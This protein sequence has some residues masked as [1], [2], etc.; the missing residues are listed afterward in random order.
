MKIGVIADTHDNLRFLNKVLDYLNKQEIS[1]L[2]HCGDWGQPF[3]MRMLT[4]LK[5]PIK[6]VLGNADPDIQKFLY[7]LQNL[8]ILKD[9]DL[10]IHERF[11]DLKFDNRKIAIFHGNDEDLNKLLVE[12]QLFDVVCIG[13]DHKP[14]IEKVKK[15]LVINPGSLIG[16]STETGEEPIT[17]AVYDTQTN[18]AKLFDLEKLE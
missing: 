11:Y 8:E 4:K 9:L 18:K 6:S 5:C 1:L 17:F 2:I 13:H 10:D 3:T 15:T 16:F 12:C 14:K 7:Q